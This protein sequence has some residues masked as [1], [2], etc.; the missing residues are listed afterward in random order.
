MNDLKQSPLPLLR[1]PDSI[2]VTN[3]KSQSQ[4]LQAA[5]RRMRSQNNISPASQKTH[6]LGDKA[7]MEA[8]MARRNKPLPVWASDAI[9]SG[10]RRHSSL[11]AP[12][13]SSAP[14][15]PVSASSSF[16][17]SPPMASQQAKKPKNPFISD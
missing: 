11:T 6:H 16:P 4:H 17:V 3:M 7:A 5:L 8:V 1:P 10:Y 13:P 2:E 14:A 9:Q 15:R 12:P